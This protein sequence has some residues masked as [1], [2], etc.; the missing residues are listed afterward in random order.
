MRD[1]YYQSVG[2]PLQLDRLPTTRP[3]TEMLPPP[4]ARHLAFSQVMTT[5]LTAV[6]AGIAVLLLYRYPGVTWLEPYDL[7][8]AGPAFVAGL[9]AWSITGQ[10]RWLLHPITLLAA[11]LLCLN[12][13][14]PWGLQVLAVSAASGLL[15]YAF[16]RHWTTVCTASP[17]ARSTADVLRSQWQLQLLALAGIAV[18][19][20]GVLLWTD[21]LLAKVAIVTL[22]LAAAVVPAPDGLCTPRWKVLVDSLVSWFTYHARPLPGILQSPVAPAR[23]RCALLVLAAVFTAIPLV[24]W[25]GSPVLRLITMAQSQHQAVTEQLT[26]RGAGAFEHLRYGTF[27]WGLTFIAIALLP[28]VLPWMLTLP[29]TMPVLLEAAAHRDRSQSSNPVQATLADLRRSPDR[30][31]RGSIYLGRVVADGSPVLVPRDVFREHAHGLGDS[32][33]GKTSL[34]LCPI[35]EQLVMQGDCSVIVLDLKAD[36]LELLGTLQ[37][38]AEAV[39]RERGVRMPLKTFSNQAAMPTFAFN[40]MTQPFWAKFDLLTRTDILCG[41]N[42]LTYG[43]D[44]GQGFYSSSNAGITHHTL[45]TFPHVNTFKE[46][47]ECIGNVISTAKRHELHPE[48]L[49]AGVHV[50]E[51]MKR[52]AACEPL[53]VTASTG[54]SPEVVQQA[55]DLTQVFQEPQLL[56]FHLSA[57]LSP[58]GAPEIARLV[59]Y[60]LLAAATQTKRRH[61]VFLVIDEFQR[62][63]ASNLEYMLQLARSMGVGVILANQSMEDLKKSTT[64]LIPAIE[65]NCRLRQWFSVSS[66]DDQQRLI[67]ASGLTVDRAVSRSVSTNS[68]GQRTV[69]YSESEQVVNRFT[70]NDVSLTS[71]HPFRS[72]LRISRGAGYAQYGGLPVI[73]ESTYHISK[74]EYDRRRSLPWPV[75]P[76]M[77]QPQ[78]FSDLEMSRGTQPHVPRSDGPQWSAE[79]INGGAAPLPEADAKSIEDMFQHFQQ[80]APADKPR[81]RRNKL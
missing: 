59:N 49:R 25:P 8:F 73:V 72:F 45:K 31:E 51:V 3:E 43:T 38:A 80:S 50:H 40:P 2:N 11:A 63:V 28:V 21:A 75:L 23:Y 47:A 77:F 48:I 78:R 54:H 76:G 5:A 41:A 1:T 15:V 30:V 7:I 81:K 14:I 79:I 29:L 4:L 74:D 70:I 44:Y 52:L 58:S 27:T 71:D 56:Y 18:F 10:V 39:R 12:H 13:R 9:A 60:M 24:R 64:N 34:F 57:T 61:P 32:G 55:I 36:T 17:T 35:I 69:S 53:N 46:L 68:D 33:A 62:M 20:T 66:S 16:G 65:A 22:P 26:D 37:A 42:G 19:L 6:G 67:N